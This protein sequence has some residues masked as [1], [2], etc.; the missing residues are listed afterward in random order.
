MEN[1]ELTLVRRPLEYTTR[2]RWES[3]SVTEQELVKL[4]FLSSLCQQG[5]HIFAAALARQLVRK[6][7]QA[8]CLAFRT[9]CWLPEDAGP[10][11][12]VVAGEAWRTSYRIRRNGRAK[13]NGSGA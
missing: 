8:I 7:E 1:P 5:D 6:L 2:A 11:R 13:C 4:C 3:R 9:Q 12:R 10:V